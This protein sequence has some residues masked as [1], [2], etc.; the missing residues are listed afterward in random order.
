M[1][2]SGG[3]LEQST[4]STLGGKIV[5]FLLF[6]AYYSYL[7]TYE[8]GCLNQGVEISPCFSRWLKKRLFSHS[9]LMG[10]AIENLQINAPWHKC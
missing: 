7:V 5:R 8:S 3:S 4:H 6:G 1:A 2:L 10:F 9:P